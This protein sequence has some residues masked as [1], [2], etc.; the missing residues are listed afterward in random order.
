MTQVERVTFTERQPP[1]IISQN[2]GV[3]IRKGKKNGIVGQTGQEK[4]IFGFGDIMLFC[5][6]RDCGKAI[7]VVLIA[8]SYN[9]KPWLY[10]RSELMAA[11]PD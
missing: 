6:L 7:K 8:P 2:Q 1:E 5:W 9:Y 3:L 11:G 10:C 4:D